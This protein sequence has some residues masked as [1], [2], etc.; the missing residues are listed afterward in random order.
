MADYAYDPGADPSKV[1]VYIPQ[2]GEDVYFQSDM[3]MHEIA[4]R[5]KEDVLPK[6]RAAAATSNQNPATPNRVQIPKFRE[7]TTGERVASD[8]AN[9]VAGVGG[10]IATVM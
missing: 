2:L 5:I 6:A 7:A 8:E 4:R 3:P 9:F 10:G 1:A